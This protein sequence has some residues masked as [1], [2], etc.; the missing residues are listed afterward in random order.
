MKKKEKRIK[1]LF[2]LKMDLGYQRNFIEYAIA[3]HDMLLKI[4]KERGNCKHD[5]FPSEFSFTKDLKW[6]FI[7]VSN[8]NIGKAQMERITDYFNQ[9]DEIGFFVLSIGKHLN[10]VNN[11]KDYIVNMQAFCDIQ[12]IIED[13]MVH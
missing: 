12:K 1:A 4:I 5:P 7:V 9:R 6:I 11:E 2:D 13:L 8:A 3:R 10:D